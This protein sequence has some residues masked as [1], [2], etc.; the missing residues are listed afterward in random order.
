[1]DKSTASTTAGA[2]DMHTPPPTPAGA[3]PTGR[4]HARGGDARADGSGL[5]TRE[6]LR[7]LSYEALIDLIL[8]MQGGR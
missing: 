2:R 5:H 4:A 6:S 3:E 8:Q 1:M 7:H